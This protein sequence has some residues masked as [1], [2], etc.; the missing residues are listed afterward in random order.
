[1]NESRNIA[2]L[3][4]GRELSGKRKERQFL[5]AY[6]LSKDYRLTYTKRITGGIKYDGNLYIHGYR[7]WFQGCFRNGKPHFMESKIKFSTE[8]RKWRIKNVLLYNSPFTQ[9][10]DNIGLDNKIY[11]PCVFVLTDTSLLLQYKLDYYTGKW[12]LMKEIHFC[13]RFKFQ[14]LSYVKENDMFQIKSKL[15]H[16]D[17]NRRDNILYFALFYPAPLT[18]IGIFRLSCDLHVNL[19]DVHI[20]DELLVILTNKEMHFYSIQEILDLARINHVNIN[21]D[22]NGS[23]SNPLREN[24]TITELPPCLLTIP[25]TNISTLSIGGFPWSCVLQEKNTNTFN[26]FRLPSVD[27]ISEITFAHQDGFERQSC[28]FHTDGTNRLVYV[29]LDHLKF[30]KFNDSPPYLSTAFTIPFNKPFKS[31]TPTI[32]SSGRTIKLVRVTSEVDV[33]PDII[34][35]IDYN[36]DLFM[37][38]VLYTNFKDSCYMIGLYDNQNGRLIKELKILAVNVSDEYEWELFFDDVTIILILRPIVKK[39]QTSCFIYQLC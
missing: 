17:R 10:N 33:L 19:K 24:I 9:L 18:F 27:K 23:S 6:I 12:L 2:D 1:M 32:T 29:E 5:R 38:G 25:M 3:F 15:H 34:H 37:F 28:C 21:R 14:T 11:E 7:K 39:S 4:M 20:Y 13:L 16:G 30:V 22:N 26:I 31:N 35:A 36:I 8:N